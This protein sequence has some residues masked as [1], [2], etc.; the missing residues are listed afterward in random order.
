M[1]ATLRRV[2]GTR[3]E[4]GRK[5]GRGRAEAL[6]WFPAGQPV[7][8]RWALTP[9]PG[10]S[11]EVDARTHVLPLGP[12]RETKAAGTR[13]PRKWA[14]ERSVRLLTVGARAGLWALGHTRGAA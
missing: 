14:R 5:G 7:S 10:R 13:P 12:S 2:A 6:L 11:G 3:G 8:C 9:G 1:S 4:L